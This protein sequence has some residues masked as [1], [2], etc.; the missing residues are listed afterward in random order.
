[1]PPSWSSAGLITARLQKVPFVPRRETEVR[2]HIFGSDG[3][4]DSI[5][6][7][8]FDVAA[9]SVWNDA[10][11]TGRYRGYRRFLSPQVAMG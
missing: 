10:D 9:D 7:F 6:S 3:G 11:P 1:M 2:V 5:T 8:A 4:T